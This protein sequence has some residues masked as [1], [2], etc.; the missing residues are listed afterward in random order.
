MSEPMYMQG[1]SI[2]LD[3]NTGATTHEHTCECGAENSPVVTYEYDIANS[4]CAYWGVYDCPKCG[5]HNEVE[6][7]DF[8]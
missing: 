2:A 3:T 5:A 4:Q 8:I 1:D 7:W 6:G